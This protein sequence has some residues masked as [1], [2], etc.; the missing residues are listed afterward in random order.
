MAAVGLA[1]RSQSSNSRRPKHYPVRAEF[2]LGQDL[3]EKSI[4]I[5]N[6][7]LCILRIQEYYLP[8]SP[9]VEDCHNFVDYRDEDQ[10]PSLPDNS[11]NNKKRY[12]RDRPQ[13][14]TL[15]ENIAST[16]LRNHSVASR[17]NAAPTYTLQPPVRTT[18]VAR[19]VLLRAKGVIVPHAGLHPVEQGGKGSSYG[20]ADKSGV[21]DLQ[22]SECVMSPFRYEQHRPPRSSRPSEARAN[23]FISRVAQSSGTVT[24]DGTHGS[25]VP[26]HGTTTRTHNG[27]SKVIMPT[28]TSPHIS[29]EDDIDSDFILQF[30]REHD[31]E[32]GAEVARSLAFKTQNYESDQQQHASPL[33]G[34][35][36]TERRPFL[37]PDVETGS[38][39]TLDWASPV[40]SPRPPRPPKS[41]KRLS[42]SPSPVTPTPPTPP[43]KTIYIPPPTTEME[44]ISPNADCPCAFDDADE[45]EVS[46]AQIPR[47]SLGYSRRLS[48]S[49]TRPGRL[50]KE[51]RISVGSRQTSR[52]HTT[53]KT[54]QTP[55]TPIDTQIEWRQAD[56][57]CATTSTVR[58][59]PIDLQ[60]SP[61][62]ASELIQ[63]FDDHTLEDFERNRRL[64][65]L[66]K[67]LGIHS[68]PELPEAG[69]SH[70]L[71]SPVHSSTAPPSSSLSYTGAQR[72]SD[73]SPGASQVQVSVAPLS[74]DSF[75]TASE[76]S[77]RIW[78]GEGYQS[79]RPEEPYDTD[80]LENTLSSTLDTRASNPGNSAD[81]HLQ[82][83]AAKLQSEAA[84]EDLRWRQSHLPE[85]LPPE[86]DID[87]IRRSLIDQR[88]SLGIT[89]SVL[90]SILAADSFYMPH[91][92]RLSMEQI[93]A[94][95]SMEQ[96]ARRSRSGSV[97]RS[98]TRGS[99]NS[100]SHRSAATSTGGATGRF[101][102]NGMK[103]AVDIPAEAPLSA[104]RS[105]SIADEQNSLP[106]LGALSNIDQS[107]AEDNV[108][109]VNIEDA[110]DALESEDALPRSQS[111]EGKASW[112][113]STLSVSEALALR[114]LPLELPEPEIENPRNVSRRRTRSSNA[115]QRLSNTF[116]GSSSKARP[117][118]KRLSSFLS[119]LAGGNKSVPQGHLDSKHAIP[120][121]DDSPEH[122]ISPHLPAMPVKPG[123]RKRAMTG[124]AKLR[125]IV[126]TMT[127]PVPDM[128][129]HVDSTIAQQ[130]HEDLGQLPTASDSWRSTLPDHVFAS[131]AKSYGRDEF[132]R[133]E[134]IH[135]LYKT[136]DSFVS[137]LK[138]VVRVFSQPLR[139]SNGRWI[140]GVPTT[141]SRLLDW[142]DDIVYLHSQLTAALQDCRYAQGHLVYRLAEVILEFIPRLEVHL[143]YL[144]RFD[145][146]THTINDMLVKSDSD[147]GEFVRMQQALPEC[148]S[149]SLTSFLLKPVQRLMKYPLFFKVSEL[150]RTMSVCIAS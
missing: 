35:V 31:L 96:R 129:S 120:T 67:G 150:M 44:P 33:G 54:P 135:E 140:S 102:S 83:Q 121:R 30:A 133:Q 18:G 56:G 39:A 53:P 127:N 46:C 103:D 48:A 149:M 95:L 1:S 37:S 122:S 10:L 141:I 20:L 84:I 25:T 124:P 104:V 113:Q 115:F 5:G 87:T 70:Y 145:A 62:P 32:L 16:S 50:R 148:G 144:V 4:L 36:T 12:A 11:N 77:L 15:C 47:Q 147:F 131:L 99:L 8:A 126:N 76:S 105:P 28:K 58:S 91:G 40:S 66:L 107:T 78:E 75:Q 116:S 142:L 13:V 60:S 88:A 82:D 98:S 125:S 65:S 137:G 79:F 41:A 7:K 93:A 2:D 136:E 6:N 128:S 49:S 22:T 119:V 106:Q 71:D 29:N 109:V 19:R 89:D 73:G 114:P 43:P 26:L 69:P 27:P 90:A 117:S 97:Q 61:S 123:R 24:S 143:P 92:A 80:S 108:E 51:R 139:T 146:V 94:R 138:G 134:V 14:T 132:L 111:R 59:Q 63:Q 112:R 100:N 68:E 110:T 42:A 86:T 21:Q 81:P 52:V 130:A 64:S 3:V 74:S 45:E 34:P 101:S 72:G 17:D 9:S 23:A 57:I 118:R 38:P 85:P 55:V